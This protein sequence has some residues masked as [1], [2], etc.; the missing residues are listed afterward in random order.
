MALWAFSEHCL[1]SLAGYACWSCL[2]FLEGRTPIA[3]A[4][5]CLEKLTVFSLSPSQRSQSVIR[6]LLQP[7]EKN[8]HKEGSRTEINSGRSASWAR[9]Y[10]IQESDGVQLGCANPGTPKNGG[11]PPFVW[12][13]NSARMLSKK[14]GPRS[15]VPKKAA[16]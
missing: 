4:G 1:H 15:F 5:G 12:H 7:V 6:N 9:I 2:A 11:F 13:S 8:G 10:L 16:S 3:G 14:T